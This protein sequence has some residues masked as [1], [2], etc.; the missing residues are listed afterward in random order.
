MKI[1]F[2]AHG[3]KFLWAWSLIWTSSYLDGFY[4]KVDVL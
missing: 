3:F 1:E 2:H 4:N